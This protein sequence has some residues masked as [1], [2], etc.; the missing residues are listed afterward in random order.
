MVSASQNHCKT[1][2]YYLQYNYVR[3]PDLSPFI[4]TTELTWY[5]LKDS[6]TEAECKIKLNN[7]S[8]EVNR[9][10]TASYLDSLL[11][12]HGKD[13]KVAPFFYDVIF[14]LY[15]WPKCSNFSFIVFIINSFESMKRSFKYTCNAPLV[16]P[17]SIIA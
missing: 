8:S 13:N 1:L 14:C 4:P 17:L 12:Q 5:L 3:M 9:S 10:I 6:Q 15:T 7:S 2:D 16:Y 11:D